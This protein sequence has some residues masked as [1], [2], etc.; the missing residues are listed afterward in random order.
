VR[1]PG[2]HPQQAC[3][4]CQ[5]S[6]RAPSPAGLIRCSACGGDGAGKEPQKK[7]R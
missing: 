1:K 6:G 4:R 7:K 2:V 5:G 3:D